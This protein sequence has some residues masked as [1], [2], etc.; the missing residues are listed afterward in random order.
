MNYLWSW[1]PGPP[2]Q[3]A[4]APAQESKQLNEAQLTELHSK[5]V[6]MQTAHMAEA[7]GLMAKLVAENQDLKEK[8][9]TCTRELKDVKAGRKADEEALEK[10]LKQAQGAMETLGD[11]YE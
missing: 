7:E 6:N 8:L 4:A 9:E 5:W 3:A 11:W 1:L 10:A 2:A